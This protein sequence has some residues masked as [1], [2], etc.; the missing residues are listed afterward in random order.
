MEFISYILGEP[1]PDER[2]IRSYDSVLTR[3]SPT[4]FE[5]IVTLTNMTAEERKALSCEKILVSLFV[6]KQIPFIVLDFGVYKC[7]VT[8]N[9]TK[10]RQIPISQWLKDEEDAVVLYILEERTGN[11]KNIRLCKFPL[12]S[13]LKSLLRLQLPLSMEEVDARIAEGEATYSLLDMQKY[14]IFLGE[15]PAVDTQI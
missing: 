3:I 13:E 7:N 10:I 1:F 15:I 8:I 9:I 4:S 2:Y 6:F 12:M 11:L 14:S 5:I